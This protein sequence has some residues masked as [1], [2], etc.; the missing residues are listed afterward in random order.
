LL[1]GI[2]WRL[3]PVPGV[4]AGGRLEVRGP[5]IMLG[6]LRDTAPGVLESV[7]DGWY[8]TG[9]IV[10]VDAPG[11]VTIVGRAKRFAK[12]GGEMVSMTAAESLVASLWPEARHA[13]VSVPDARKGEALLLV[14]THKDAEP[15]DLLAFARQRGVP[16]LMVP[17]SIQVVGVVP[18]LATGKVDYPAVEQMVREARVDAEPEAVTV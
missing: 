17:R 7:T 11:F 13:V 5:T 8:D 3:Q 14:T 18:L 1:P 9:D 16:E 2:A 12:I 10:S 15:R 6:Y 4:D